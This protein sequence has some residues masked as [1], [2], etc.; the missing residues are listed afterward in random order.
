M[1][2]IASI[3]ESRMPSQATKESLAGYRGVEGFLPPTDVVIGLGIVY[4]LVTYNISR[5][6]V[7]GMRSIA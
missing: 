1:R 6:F 4:V 7:G 2:C 3:P 5:R